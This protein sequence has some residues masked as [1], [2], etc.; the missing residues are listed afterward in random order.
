MSSCEVEQIKISGKNSKKKFKGLQI[1]L[2]KILE[3][4]S[5]LVMTFS[6]NMPKAQFV[7]KIIYKLDFIKI[8]NFCE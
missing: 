8:K 1:K 2:T 6:F 3:F 5:D 7:K 4:S